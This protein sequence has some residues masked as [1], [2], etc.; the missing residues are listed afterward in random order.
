MRKA[1]CTASVLCLLCAALY[2]LFLLACIPVPKRWDWSTY[3]FNEPSGTE[4]LFVFFGGTISPVL[5]AIV[6]VAALVKA[7]SAICSR[8]RR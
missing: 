1:L 6:L 3:L 2:G 8:L 7:S 4:P 5:L